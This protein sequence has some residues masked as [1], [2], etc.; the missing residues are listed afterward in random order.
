MCELHNAAG[1]LLDW[2]PSVQ[3]TVVRSEMISRLEGAVLP[4]GV[5]RPH[6][7]VNDIACQIPSGDLVENTS[8]EVDGSMCSPP[9]A[10]RSCDE[11]ACRMWYD[12]RN[13]TSVEG[14]V[15]P[16]TMPVDSAI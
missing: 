5:C 8:F 14:V 11:S 2:Q 1:T 16:D 7:I 15:F 13:Q 9:P 6:G 10:F 3:T 4:G 12:A